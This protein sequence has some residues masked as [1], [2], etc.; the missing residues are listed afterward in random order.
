MLGAGI[1]GAGS[2]RPAET[3]LKGEKGA[4]TTLAGGG[5]S[6]AWVAN[7]LECPLPQKLR[8][9]CRVGLLQKCLLLV[10]RHLLPGS[11]NLLLVLLTPVVEWRRL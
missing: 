5:G 8:R 10:L 6:W 2:A 7:P 4:L 11:Q 9:E 1:F 3:V